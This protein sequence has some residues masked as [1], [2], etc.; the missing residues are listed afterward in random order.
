MFVPFGLEHHLTSYLFK[1]EPVE[2]DTVR[3]SRGAVNRS[4]ALSGVF[5]V[6]YVDL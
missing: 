3:F 6:Y 4:V 2:R 5:N 1:L